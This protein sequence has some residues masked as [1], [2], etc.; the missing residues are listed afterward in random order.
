M[1]E[2][3][4][5]ALGGL[6]VRQA[7]LVD[8][9]IRLQ[10]APSD[11]ETRSFLR[12]IHK[13]DDT[14]GLEIEV[15]PELLE[16]IILPDEVGTREHKLA[17]LPGNCI[18]LKVAL[19]ADN[20]LFAVDG[21]YDASYFVA[22][23][24]KTGFRPTPKFS[25]LVRGYISDLSRSF[26]FKQVR[27][28]FRDTNG[29][30]VPDDETQALKTHQKAMVRILTPYSR[31]FCGDPS[32]VRQLKVSG[33]E[34]DYLGVEQR[35]DSIQGILDT[36]EDF[37]RQKPSS[38]LYGKVTLSDALGSVADSSWEDFS[39]DN[40]NATLKNTRLGYAVNALD[41]HIKTK[42]SPTIVDHMAKVCGKRFSQDQREE[43]AR[44]FRRFMATLIDASQKRMEPLR[45]F[46]ASVGQ[47]NEAVP[48]RG[49]ALLNH[50][51]GLS[52]LSPSDE[53]KLAD[54][55]KL[56]FS[57]EMKK[58]FADPRTFGAPLEDHPKS[59]QQAA[60]SVLLHYTSRELVGAYWEI[61]NPSPSAASLDAL[62]SETEQKV[63]DRFTKR[64]NPVS[65][66]GQFYQDFVSARNLIVHQVE[67][68]LGPPADHTIL[69]PPK[70]LQRRLMERSAGVSSV[71][72]SRGLLLNSACMIFRRES[73]PD[74]A[75]SVLLREGDLLSGR[76]AGAFGEEAGYVTKAYGKSRAEA[77][78]ALLL[79]ESIQQH[80]VQLA[81]KLQEF[82][83]AHVKDFKQKLEDELD[84][85]VRA[86]TLTVATLGKRITDSPAEIYKALNPKA[87]VRCE[88]A[89]AK[90][91]V[92]SSACM[93]VL[94]QT[95]RRKLAFYKQSLP[96]S[97]ELNNIEG[98]VYNGP[99]SMK[100]VEELVED[101]TEDGILDFIR[102]SAIRDG[103]LREH[104]MDS[105]S[106]H[107]ADRASRA[108]AA[109]EIEAD[110]KCY[111]GGMS[112]RRHARHL[113]K[114]AFNKAVMGKG[115][116]LQI[117]PH[118]FAP[119]GIA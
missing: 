49:L 41:N 14:D 81:Q 71:S 35:I 114:D 101:N 74:D 55:T 22:G 105:H 59:V 50:L 110:S 65:D 28:F 117:D 75:V 40:L 46:N 99:Q 98:M 104:A 63:V 8:K 90:A 21:T 68:Y 113:L 15:G 39:R 118:M 56:D 61:S 100:M 64:K 115:T 79:H 52:R 111:P 119:P 30:L 44:E 107:L 4:V 20:E 43:L 25:R 7:W 116:G 96:S 24:E 29:R 3:E 45:R 84:S 9:K 1:T 72:R 103:A 33:F 38:P 27:G 23:D 94:K 67:E 112:P 88:L 78:F 48:E 6:W 73:I 18:N 37:A 13:L 77:A 87:E 17:M 92:V 51:A 93:E 2:R 106:A 97:I 89:N 62:L 26:V 42:L 12:H 31:P 76:P 32:K 36:E 69:A 11:D 10:L 47:A 82:G 102:L 60:N 80:N 85:R 95:L 54:G 16:R 86:R 108:K 70:T 34:G 57:A 66:P 5:H 109:V 83:E 19:D 53:F 58:L 91:S